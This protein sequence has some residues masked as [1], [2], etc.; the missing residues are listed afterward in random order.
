MLSAKDNQNYQNFVTKDLKRQCIRMSAKQD[1][2][3]KF[4]IKLC[5]S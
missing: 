1:V 2:R 3:V 4:S 5:G